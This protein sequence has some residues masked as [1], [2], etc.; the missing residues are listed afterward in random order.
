[1]STVS[2]AMSARRQSVLYLVGAVFQGLGVVLVQPFSVRILGTGEWGRVGVSMSMLQVGM[3]VIS[4]G[5]PLAV[6]RSFYDPAQGPARARSVAGFQILLGLA[7]GTAVSGGML[8]VAVARGDVV[9]VLPFAAAV[10]TVGLYAVIT[11]AQ[12]LLR[13]E[14][15]PIAFVAL[16]TG[17]TIGA[18]GCGLVAILLVSPSA[19]AYLTAFSGAVLL[20][21][22]VS[23]R[24]A[25]PA[26]PW[27]Y[28][29]AVHEAVRISLPVVPHSVALTFLLQGDTMLVK[30]FAG[31]TVAGYYAA[32]AP[33]SLG[34]VTLLA[35]LN[36]VWTP[37]IMAAQGKDRSRRVNTVMHT[38]ALSAAG[39]ASLAMLV[40]I[41]GG[42]VLGGTAVGRLTDLS[43]APTGSVDTIID[44]AKVLPLI[45]LGYALYLVATS[46]LFAARRTSS[47]AW[48]TLSVTA[49]AMAAFTWPAAHGSLLLMGAVKVVSYAL[50]GCAYLV[51]AVR[52]T[53]IRLRIG[54]LAG[55]G[56][57]SIVLC[58][59]LLLVP[60]TMGW[61]L[62]VLAVGA[63][64]G[65]VAAAVLHRRRHVGD[66]LV[67]AATGAVV[68]ATQTTPASIPEEKRC[69]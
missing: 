25:R 10:F 15:R 18:H 9:D 41:V 21:S 54:T 44:L 67:P 20:A 31:D 14:Q 50:L 1:M 5:L 35:A 16:T 39:I 59:L 23:L 17:A 64:L 55:T 37:S 46:V 58:G 69:P 27:Q 63:V 8:A 68:A 53:G 57:A 19:T 3:V 13:A 49:L 38:A 32:A 56:A 4:A 36:N 61:G 7:A 65:I 24:V 33:F 12:A 2:T 51:I 26:A 43:A 66:R 29:A 45:A 42:H 48:V 11:A 30:S 6:A 22:A 34:V 60:N 47:L 40:A 28:R 52:V 62:L